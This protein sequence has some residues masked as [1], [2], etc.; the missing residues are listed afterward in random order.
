MRNLINRAKRIS[1]VVAISVVST[2]GILIIDYLERQEQKH[3]IR[4]PVED[5]VKKG[6]EAGDPLDYT[7]DW[8]SKKESGAIKILRVKK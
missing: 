6:W 1:P 8:S 7:A 3:S 4:I 2:V 5:Y